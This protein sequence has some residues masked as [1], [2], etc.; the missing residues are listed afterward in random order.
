MS[1]KNT[2]KTCILPL[3]NHPFY[4]FAFGKKVVD[5][6]NG[7]FYQFFAITIYYSNSFTIST[8]LSDK[9]LHNLCKRK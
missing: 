3:P 8:P 6:K 9:N 5:G 2:K 4:F 1:T 7:Y